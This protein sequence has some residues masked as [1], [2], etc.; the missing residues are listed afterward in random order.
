MTDT[1][2]NGESRDPNAP[3]E[4]LIRVLQEDVKL[5][6]SLFDQLGS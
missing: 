4:E 2:T 3:L 1:T 5:R 6:T